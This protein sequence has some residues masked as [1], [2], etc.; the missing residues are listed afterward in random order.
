MSSGREKI[1]WKERAVPL[2]R[3]GSWYKGLSG[4]IGRRKGGGGS[5]C[6]DGG[7]CSVE[8]QCLSRAWHRRGNKRSAAGGG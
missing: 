3:D 7:V 6:R 4:P 8:A 2:L 1:V 5:E